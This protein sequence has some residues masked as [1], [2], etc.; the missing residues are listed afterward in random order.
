MSTDNDQR[1]TGFELESNLILNKELVSSCD[2]STITFFFSIKKT[3]SRILIQCFFCNILKSPSSSSTDT[4]I[5][6]LPLPSFTLGTTAWLTWLIHP[7]ELTSPSGRSVTILS[8][9]TNSLYSSPSCLMDAIT[10]FCAQLQT[11][12]WEPL[13]G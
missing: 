8:T 12:R 11:E 10:A 9:G 5:R 13:E 7:S 6:N 1:V 2:N 3:I 4:H